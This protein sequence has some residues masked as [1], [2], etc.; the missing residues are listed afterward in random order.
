[1]D[2]GT[3]HPHAVQ[4]GEDLLPGP[5]QAENKNR[6]ANLNAETMHTQRGNLLSQRALDR[7][8]PN[9]AHVERAVQDRVDTLKS[10]PGPAPSAVKRCPI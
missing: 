4:E 1:M 2:K 7:T 6:S 3:S 8:P 5:T 10:P 9:A